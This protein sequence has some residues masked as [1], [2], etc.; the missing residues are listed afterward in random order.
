MKVCTECK[1]KIVENTSRCTTCKKEYVV[2]TYKHPRNK[3]WA[4]TKAILLSFVFNVTALR[5]I[6]V[7]VGLS[8]DEIWLQNVNDFVVMPVIIYFLFKYF[9]NKTATVVESV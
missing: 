5:W 8:V 6:E 7:Q 9:S 4:V 1:R 2:K 3:I